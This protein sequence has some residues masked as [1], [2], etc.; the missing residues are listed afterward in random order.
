MIAKKPTP[1]DTNPHGLTPNQI[2]SINARLNKFDAKIVTPN[3]TT[4]KKALFEPDMPTGAAWSKSAQNYQSPA[5]GKTYF[6]QQQPYA[7]EVAT[8]DR[9]N[10]PIHRVLANRYWRLFYKLDPLVGNIIDMMGD[11]PWSRFR[12]NGPGVDGSVLRTMETMCE[13]SNLL[14]MLPAMVR[15]FLV[16]GECVP[17]LLFSEDK[18]YWT[19]IALHNPD[20]IEVVDAPF[21]KME[22]V[23]QFVPDDRLREV[24]NSNDPLLAH[25]REKMPPQMLS[26]LQS[27]QNIPLSP[28]N[29]TF[30]PRKMH[31]Y[32]IRG[33]SIMSRLWRIFNYEDAVYNTSIQVARRSAHPIKVCKLG[34]PTTGWIPG[35]EHEAKLLQLL[36]QAELDPLAF[37][38][39]HYGVNFEMIGASERAMSI[40]KELET[41]D[42]V[43][44]MAL[45]VNKGFLF[46][47]VTYA[48]A[49]T[50]LQV[51]LQRLKALRM[52]FEQKWLL[53]KFFRVISEINGWV[54]S[55]PAEVSHHFRVK[56]SQ[57]EM[58]EQE[59]YIIPNVIWDKSLDP[60]VDANLINAMQTLEQLGVKFSKTTK[61]ATIGMSFEEEAH[62]VAEER[63]YEKQ[64]LPKVQPEQQEGA[65]AGGAPGGGGGMAPEG[66]PP[67]A[68]GGGGG[69][70][71]GG[72]PPSDAGGAP[73]SGE[74]PAGPPPPGMEAGAS[75]KT[76]TKQKQPSK[77]KTIEKDAGPKPSKSKHENL[78]SSIW[79]DEK[80]GN[81][82][83][84]EVSEL[85]SIFSGEDSREE[86]WAPMMADKNM[87]TAMKGEDANDKW[88][89]VTK[90]LEESGYPDS[91]IEELQHILTK[92]EILDND[93]GEAAFSELEGLI[94]APS[95]SDV[96]MFVGADAESPRMNDKI[97][98]DLTERMASIRSK[99]RK[100]RTGKNK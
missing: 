97:S 18:G 6:T 82:T 54:R 55:T 72:P 68:A 48:N 66:P 65:P 16:L 79:I 51:F 32:D 75:L 13:E 80:F 59:R 34:N 98:S 53:P 19:H 93:N 70:E 44:L 20:Q 88:K 81:W 7:P 67:D 11:L 46:G 92:E 76:A 49:A 91:D 86:P 100:R 50:G 8:P 56:R 26:Q 41:I 36:A 29:A 87:Q 25:I 43:K 15:E 12:L 33:T 85:A 83:S 31:P 2:K 28:I 64:F 94:T 22:P 60:A 99:E 40:T 42:R 47:E 10:Y 9:Q 5:S 3:T 37:I 84:D 57:R 58:I 62:K 35:P 17:H 95:E 39:T 23:L 69:D 78:K 77:G 61:M 63:E 71:M 1:A 52:Y 27:R 73:P 89:V 21:I 45:G 74:A 4:S 14:G 38:I 96:N 90:F 30:I 24:V